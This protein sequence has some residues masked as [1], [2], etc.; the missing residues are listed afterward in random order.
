MI[1]VRLKCPHCGE[2]LMDRENMIDSKSSVKLIA[3]CGENKGP[4]NMSA[5]YGNYTIKSAF[6]LPEGEIVRV[7]CPHCEKELTGTRKCE[8]CDADMI[9]LAL[10]EGGTVQI[11]SR[12][13][14]KKHCFEFDDPE[15]QIRTFYTKYST[16]FK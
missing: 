2:S 1:K 5:V 9:P 16:F 3:A 8:S 11:C 12:R 7:F 4:I 14:C 13:G 15:V 10:E 6:K